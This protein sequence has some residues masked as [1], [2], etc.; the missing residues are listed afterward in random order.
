MQKRAKR[1]LVQS[2]N[3]RALHQCRFLTG[4]SPSNLL[5]KPWHGSQQQILLMFL[6]QMTTLFILSNF[7]WSYKCQLLININ[8]MLS[9]GVDRVGITH[10]SFDFPPLSADLP[11]V[12]VAVL[13]QSSI[14]DQSFWS[15]D[16]RNRVDSIQFVH[17]ISSNTSTSPSTPNQGYQFLWRSY[18]GQRCSKVGHKQYP[19]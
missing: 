17:W 13:P 8:L 10:A 4:Y 15:A 19:N 3:S 16:E 5:T 12:P 14:A 2:S 6:V 11:S 18:P 1:S 9:I 7:Y